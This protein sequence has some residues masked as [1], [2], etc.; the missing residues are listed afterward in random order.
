MAKTY[1]KH[2][3]R[4]LNTVYSFVRIQGK[5]L[6]LLLTWL[7]KVLAI[8]RMVPRMITMSFGRGVN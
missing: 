4:L 5:K 3:N 1:R 2:N 6:V 8:G 7:N